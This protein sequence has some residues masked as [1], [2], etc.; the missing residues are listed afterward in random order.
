MGKVI[1]TIS[2][3][4]HPEKRDEYLALTKEMK[5]LLAQKKCKGYSIYEQKGKKNSFSEIFVCESLD[6]Y[7]Q[8]EDQD[9]E[10]NQLV[11]RLEPLLSNGK[12][13]YTTLVELE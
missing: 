13:K 7:E 3:E 9:E 8:L 12:M 4:I 10:T 6:E 2:Y 5:Q 1:F 11:Q